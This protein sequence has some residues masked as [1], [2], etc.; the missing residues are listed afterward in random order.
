MAQI[1][2]QSKRYRDINIFTFTEM[3]EDEAHEKFVEVRWGDRNSV[4]C[5]CCGTIGSHYYIASRKKW[6]CKD[7]SEFFSV[8]SSTILE[9]RK[10]TFRIILVALF[11]FVA[12]PKSDGANRIHPILGVTLRTVY[13]LFGKFREALWEQRDTSQLTGVVHIDGGHFC[14]KPRRPRIRQKANAK[15]IDSKLRNRKAN[16]IPTDSLAR[17][18]PWNQEKLENRRIVLV[19]REVSSDKRIGGLRTR[20]AIV[21]AETRAHVIQAIRT[22]VS[23]DATTVITDFSAA[24]RSLSSWY[25][26]EAVNHSVEYSTDDGVN[27]NQA[28]SF[29][30]RMRRSEFGILHGMRPQY[31][32]L[33][34]N[35]FAW[36]EDVRFCTL[37]EKF[38]MLLSMILR[39]G[40]SKA[41]R[42]YNQGHRLEVE[43]DGIPKAEAWPWEETI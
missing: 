17:I 26:H 4:S 11:L 43:Y 38:H 22:Y 10:L 41:W 2:C 21:P 12:A 42:G 28:E 7:C 8:T 40:L 30:A 29:M 15:A 13:M 25:E 35:E 18:E 3:S 32:A 37:G 24:Y 5:P 1:H 16:L 19:M 9:G 34:A 36:R 33:Y 6:R 39:T 31:L 23:S 27:Q 14:G 20:I